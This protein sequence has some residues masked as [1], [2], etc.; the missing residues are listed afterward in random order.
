MKFTRVYVFI[1]YLNKDMEIYEHT[2]QAS[3]GEYIR[4]EVSGSVAGNYDVTPP[5]SF[6][7]TLKSLTDIN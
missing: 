5:P 2:D 4:N 6:R 1:V 3:S 7:A